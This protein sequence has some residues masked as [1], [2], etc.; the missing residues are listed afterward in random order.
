LLSNAS[1]ID[2]A[3][4]PNE[5]GVNLPLAQQL[6]NFFSAFFTYDELAEQLIKL[7]VSWNYPLLPSS[8][9]ILPAIELPVLLAA[10]FTFEIP[11]DYEIPAG[12]C[13]PAFSA[14]DPFVCRLANALKTWYAQLKPVTKGAWFQ[15]DISVFSSLNESKL[16]L[17]ELDN[18]M[19]YYENIQDL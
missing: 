5:A 19:L 3:K 10:P 14:S 1:P 9:G 2:I 4:I 13:Q 12:G 18:I 11:S 6:A 16:P 8:T 17:I 15:F 7:S